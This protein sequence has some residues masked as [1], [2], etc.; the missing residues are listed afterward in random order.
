MLSDRLSFSVSHLHWLTGTQK[1]W[2]LLSKYLDNID[3]HGACILNRRYSNDFFGSIRSLLPHHHLIS[4]SVWAWMGRHGLKPLIRALSR[5]AWL[6]EYHRG[7]TDPS[8]ID[9][10]GPASLMWRW[11]QG[12]M[13]CSEPLS[14]WNSSEISPYLQPI[15]KSTMLRLWIGSLAFVCSNSAA[16]NDHCDCHIQKIKF[17]A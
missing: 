7:S 11:Y 9:F 17:A 3:E 1:C 16:T 2:R 13:F 8:R 10:Q 12:L 14:F 15:H 5:L 6:E 4:I